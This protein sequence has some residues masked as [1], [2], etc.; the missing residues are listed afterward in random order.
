MKKLFFIS[1]VLVLAGCSGSL[2][3]NTEK[4]N[5]RHQNLINPAHLN[6]LCQNVTLPNG[7]KSAL[8][9]VY[10]NYPEYKWTDAAGQ[11]ISCVDDVTRAGV[12][13]HDYYKQTGEKEYIERVERLVEFVLYLHA[14]NGYFY[15]F[16]NKDLSINRDGITSKAE[17]NWWT[18]RAMWFL[19]YV[20]PEMKEWNSEVS[21][22]IKIVMDKTIATVKKNIPLKGKIEYF[23]GIDSAGWLPDGAADQSSLILMGLCYYYKNIQKDQDLV[24]MMNRLAEGLITMQI[25]DK[26]SEVFGALLCWKNQWHGWGANQAYAL[27]VAGQELKNKKL[28]NAALLEID[29][30][31]NYL[32]KQNYLR[33]FTLQKTN[34]KISFIK[35]HQF[36]QIAYAIG[37]M[38]YSTIK[39]Y[40]IT[41][42][43]KYA[44]QAVKLAMWFF[45]DNL[46]EVD[47]Y[48][49][50]T[51]LVFDGIN[52]V[53]DYNRNSGAESTIECLMALIAIMSNPVTEVKLN[54][55]LKK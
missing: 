18:W 9:H 37:P 54:S 23:D 24:F 15:N 26:E 21:D 47:M 45:G 17:A 46:A 4:Q 27:L 35:K 8:V 28:I 19:A 7:A 34:G 42:N 2:K 38:V 31:Y 36:S 53:T 6:F 40:E 3:Q 29:Y 33:N 10:C 39:A 25:D 11:G 50:K 1:L 16:V 43:E 22:K 52:S 5:I 44:D 49:I 32:I 20:Y 13:Y 12:F 55:A 14:D 30:F 48:N 41:E 51:G